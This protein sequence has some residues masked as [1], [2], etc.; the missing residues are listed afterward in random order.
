MLGDLFPYEAVTVT[1]YAGGGV[2]V[3]VIVVAGGQVDAVE[4]VERRLLLGLDEVGGDG[5]ELVAI[6]VVVGCPWLEDEVGAVVVT[7]N[8]DE[9]LDEAALLLEEL[10]AEDDAE[11]Y[12]VVIGYSDVWPLLTTARTCSCAN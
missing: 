5:D 10:A 11:E 4:E 2:A 9:G 3:T 7:A 6:V 1:V 12:D 8:D